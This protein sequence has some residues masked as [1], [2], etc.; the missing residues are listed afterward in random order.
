[1]YA[2]SLLHKTIGERCPNIH[3]ARM[4]ACCLAVQALTEGA[5]ATVTSLGRGLSG[6][7]YDK[8]KIKRADRLLSNQFLQQEL[9]VFYSALAHTLLKNLSEPIILIDWSPMCAD[10]SRQLLRAAIPVGGRALTLYEEVHPRSKLGN[11]RIQHQFLSQLA[12]LVP[13]QCQPIIVADSGFRTP[14]YRYVEKTLQWHWVGRIRSRDF[15]SFS[16]ASGQWFSAKSLY[17]KATT[18][19]KYLG[20]ID[21]VRRNPLASR[22]VLIRQPKKKRQD[23]T[24]SGIA[25][26]SKQSHSHASR[27][28]E[29]WLL[30]YSISLKDRTPKQLVAIYRSRMQIE[31]G[32]R[33]HK[34]ARYGM[35]ITQ[36]R[37]MGEKRR[38]VLCLLATLAHFVLWC[39]GTAGKETAQAKQ[40]R[41]NSSSKRTPYSAIFLARLLIAQKRFRLPDKEIIA[42]L[43]QI[44]I[45]VEI[46]LCC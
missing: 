16:T 23:L 26:R 7:A 10:Q 31:E 18:K 35:G 5:K 45:N 30:V 4:N 21:W 32:F 42:S 34:A 13:T 36:H 2:L 9:K 46:V 37:T 25:R 22:L 29:P 19:A 39:V 24:Y 15:I 43:R 40:V 6:T 12:S 14:F 3:A 1:M 41:V 28:R 17:A 11:R 8:H 33:D 38:A 27:E 44:R 20:Q